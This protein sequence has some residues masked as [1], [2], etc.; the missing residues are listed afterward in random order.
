MN[1]S[2]DQLSEKNFLRTHRGTV[3]GTWTVQVAH[4][5]CKRRVVQEN[6]TTIV[7]IIMPRVIG[8]VM[9]VRMMSERVVHAYSFLS[10]QTEEIG[11]ILPA[12]LHAHGADKRHPTLKK[13]NSILI[14]ARNEHKRGRERGKKR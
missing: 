2:S 9:M 1:E 13:K 7:R 3:V 12:L 8:M 14:L 4:R 6:S 10:G 11:Q 5:R